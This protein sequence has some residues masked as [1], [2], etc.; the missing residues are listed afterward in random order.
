MRGT[1][2]LIAADDYG[3]LVPLVVEPRI[4]NS[5]RRLA[6]EGVAADTAA[7]AIGLIERTLESDG[8][9][10]RPEIAERLARH[11][12]RIE[13]QV[14]AHLVWLASARGVICYG[15]DRGRDRCFVLVRDWL[16]EPESMEREP[17]L[18]ELAVRYLRAHGPSVPADFAL[19]SGLRHGDAQRAW[20]E[21]AGRLTEVATARG[22]LWSLKSH[23]ELAPR[24]LVR[25]LPF[26][27]EYLLGWKDRGVAVPAHHMTR[28]NRGGGWIHPVV[29]EDGRA[30]GTWSMDAGAQ[31][32]V[33]PF[34]QF[35]STLRRKVVADARDV[36]AF[37]ERPVEVV[38]N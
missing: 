17:A 7:S 35:A 29:V 18:A 21:V 4:T 5:Y 33:H 6:Q 15:P 3:W 25:L 24:G 32:V 30:V 12:I 19:W 9:L 14:I 20:R 11:R 13:G 27:D 37:L 22:P 2:H 1:L 28:I 26:F 23:S 38:V 31:L 16:G 10:T 8:P 34:A 36:A